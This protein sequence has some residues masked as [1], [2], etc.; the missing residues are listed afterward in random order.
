M[1]S[2]SLAPVIFL[3][4]PEGEDAADDEHEEGG[5]DKHAEVTP[6]AGAA[7]PRDLKGIGRPNGIYSVCLTFFGLVGESSPCGRFSSSSILN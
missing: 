5:E 1:R 3:E 7:K 2:S 4:V 6:L